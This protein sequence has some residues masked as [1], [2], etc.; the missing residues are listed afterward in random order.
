MNRIKALREDRDLSQ[1]QVEK[2][3]KLHSSSIVK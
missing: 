2:L 3:L 1:A